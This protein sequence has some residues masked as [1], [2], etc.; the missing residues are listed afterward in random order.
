MLLRMGYLMNTLH[1]HVDYSLSCQ[2]GSSTLFLKRCLDIQLELHLDSSSLGTRSHVVLDQI[3]HVTLKRYMF[4]P[5][6]K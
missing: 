5:G 2:L 6:S 1:Q 4:S 3:V